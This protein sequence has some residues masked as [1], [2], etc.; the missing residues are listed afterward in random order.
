MES[1]AGSVD[2]QKVRALGLK[3]KLEM[4]RRNIKNKEKELLDE[5]NR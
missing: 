3:S 1:L 5:I 4:E 2:E